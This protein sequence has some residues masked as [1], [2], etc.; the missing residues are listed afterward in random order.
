MLQVWYTPILYTD[1][2]C[3]CTVEYPYKGH[4]GTRPPITHCTIAIDH[5]C[6]NTHAHTHSHTHTHTHT[7]THSHTLTHTHTVTHTHSHTHTVTHIHKHTHTHT[8]SHTHTGVFSIINNNCIVSEYLKILTF[9]TGP[10]RSKFS[11]LRILQ[12]VSKVL[13]TMAGLNLC[14]KPVLYT[15]IV[16]LYCTC[17][18]ITVLHTVYIVHVH[19]Y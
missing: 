4:F 5:T 1:Y 6:I 11:N 17:D 18:T 12:K 16:N 9:N 2:N 7:H 15:C 10:Y 14:Y 8:Q 19:V 13:H 3:T